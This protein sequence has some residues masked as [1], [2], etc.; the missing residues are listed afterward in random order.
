MLEKGTNKSS[1]SF[2]FDSLREAL[3]YQQEVGGKMNKITGYD[4]DDKE[5][6]R[7]YYCLTVTD[8]VALI[9]T[10]KR[11]YLRKGVTASNP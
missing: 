1:K 10:K 3:Y 6:D 5:L 11:I 4:E 9:G 7:K 2:A 8:R